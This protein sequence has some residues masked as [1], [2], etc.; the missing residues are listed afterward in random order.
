MSHT[1]LRFRPLA[2]LA[3][4]VAA[5]AA[6]PPPVR[7][8]DAPTVVFADPDGGYDRFAWYGETS[9][10]EIK[11]LG[12]VAVRAGIS[13]GYVA[14]DDELGAVVP[15]QIVGTT[16]GF[17]DTV[18]PIDNT[19]LTLLGVHDGL[20]AIFTDSDYNERDYVTRFIIRYDRDQYLHDLVQIRPGHPD[21]P[22]RTVIPRDLYDDLGMVFDIRG[23]DLAVGTQFVYHT[24]DGEELSRF[25]VTVTG[26]EAVYTEL[27]YIDS[28]VLEWVTEPLE[29]VAAL[30]F[31]DVAL[32]P[33]FRPTGD[34]EPVA[35]SYVSTD[36]RRL[37]VGG[38]V[39]TDIGNMTIRI[40]SLDAP[41]TAY[42]PPSLED[43]P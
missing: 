21:R 42:S 4:A 29:S 15:M 19:S 28:F 23:R 24:H 32:P 18:Y 22:R 25:T 1:R 3:A 40:T 34:P 27:G 11:I 26:T 17:F 35:K 7:A 2:A 37:L 9:T 14:H 16:V 38:D 12:T 20:R 43:V 6:T 10:Y 5:V 31:G 33:A 36:S 8:Q 13:V 41:S 30:P 39:P